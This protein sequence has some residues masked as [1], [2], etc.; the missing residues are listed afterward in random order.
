MKIEPLGEI[1]THTTIED[2]L[3]STEININY[4]PD[5]PLRFVLNGFE[6]DQAP[7]EFVT[8]IENFMSLTTKDRA[9]AAFYVF[10]NYSEFVEAV[11]PDEFDFVV[12][13]PDDIWTHIQPSEIHVSR[14]AYGDRKVYVSVAANCDWEEE[15][16]LQIVYREGKQLNRVSD[17]DGHVT[18]SD[19]YGLPE[20]EDR[21][22]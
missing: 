13:A 17:Q 2:W 21:I 5:T 12:D 15:H 8:A 4:F 10:K 6:G 1:T 18:Y 14:R 22:C 16:G 3:V 11:G 20:S 19:A 9:E 7:E